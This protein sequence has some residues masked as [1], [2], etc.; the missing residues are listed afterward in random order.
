MK[1]ARINPEDIDKYCTDAWKT[2]LT[3]EHDRKTNISAGKTLR[4]DNQE[5]HQKFSAS[6]LEWKREERSDEEEEDDD[7]EET[8][9]IPVP[10]T[11]LKPSEF[12]SLRVDRTPTQCALELQ[13]PQRSQAW[14]DA[15]KYSITASQF[16]SAAG[17]SPYQSSDALLVDKLWNTFQGNAATDWG[18]FHEPHAKES[19]CAWLKEFMGSTPHTFREENLM[20]FSAEPWMAVSPDGLVDYERNGKKCTDLVEFKCPAFLRN[21]ADHPYAKWPN[22][23]PPQ[24]LAQIQGIMGYLNTHQSVH[25]QR[26]WFVVWQPHQTWITLVDFDQ[27]YYSTLHTKIKDWYFKELLPAFTHQ[28]NGLLNY[29]EVKPCEPIVV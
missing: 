2:V 10:Q 12:Y 25:I 13:A 16:G 18:T 17:L 6:Q 15:R 29:G 11:K 23:I 14:L 5:E 28:A 21:T 27:E 26:C 22:N 4:I 1:K 7:E 20:K 9:A 8:E 24:Y 3:A 19:F